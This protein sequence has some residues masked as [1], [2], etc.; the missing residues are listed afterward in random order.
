MLDE[1][2][3]SL[4]KAVKTTLRL[5]REKGREELTSRISALE[6]DILD[7][8]NQIRKLNTQVK[9]N[10][11]DIL[12]LIEWGLKSGANPADVVGNISSQTIQ[13]V[14]DLNTSLAN[15]PKNKPNKPAS[16][17]DFGSIIER[18]KC[19]DLDSPNTKESGDE[20]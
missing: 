4:K 12:A 20:S 8:L 10:V 1:L 3:D 18:G 14:S 2:P 9:A 17:F 15:D 19:L 7:L 13:F 16:L 5:D 11:F 6:L